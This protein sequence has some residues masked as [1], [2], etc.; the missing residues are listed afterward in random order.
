MN[1]A[2]IRLFVSSSADY[3]A[4]YHVAQR[5]P[6]VH[7]PE[8]LKWMGTKLST[9]SASYYCNFINI[10]AH[11][12]FYKPCFALWCVRSRLCKMQVIMT[13]PQH[14]QWWIPNTSFNAASIPLKPSRHEWGELSAQSTTLH[15]LLHDSAAGISKPSV[16]HSPK[17]PWHRTPKL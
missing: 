14:Q 10:C 3:H 17:S 12:C 1:L 16:P 15:S 6:L 7:N 5:Q 2:R 4:F 13:T 9:C 11:S 8:S